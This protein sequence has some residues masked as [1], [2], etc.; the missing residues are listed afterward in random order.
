M[1]RT[2]DERDACPCT[3][4]PLTRASG[5]L[6]G[7][8]PRAMSRSVSKIADGVHGHEKASQRFTSWQA[9]R[10]P[11][12]RGYPASPPDC[13]RDKLLEI[14]RPSLP[15][16]AEGL[17]PV[18][19]SALVAG[20][21]Q[22]SPLVTSE[23]H[24][25]AQTTR[26]P[27]KQTGTQGGDHAHGR[28]TSVRECHALF[29][30]PCTRMPRWVSPRT[31]ASSVW[32]RTTRNQFPVRPTPLVMRATRNQS[33]CHLLE[34]KECSLWNYYCESRTFFFCKRKQNMRMVSATTSRCPT[35]AGAW[36]GVHRWRWLSRLCCASLSDI[37]GR[38]RAS[39]QYCTQHDR[40][41][42]PTLRPMGPLAARTARWDVQGGAHHGSVL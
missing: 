30:P 2:S 16:M 23:E 3:G 21:A 27:P 10:P 28:A 22:R 18:E 35:G 42:V 13:T 29:C 25:R 34:S 36:S 1:H 26:A 6:G 32:R 17:L 31:A 14:A 7:H 24:T 9:M 11:R 8:L 20:F 15:H 38:E 39:M 5:A 4:D 33:L 37:T 40:L 12:R 19:A 41:Y